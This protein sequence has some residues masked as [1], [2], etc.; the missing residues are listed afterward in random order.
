[1]PTVPH[2]PLLTALYGVVCVVGLV[3]CAIHDPLHRRRRPAASTYWVS[4]TADRSR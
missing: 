2:R 1:M 4:T 3:V